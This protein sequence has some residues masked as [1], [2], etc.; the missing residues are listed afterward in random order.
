MWLA[1]VVSLSFLVTAPGASAQTT[2]TTTLPNLVLLHSDD[3]GWTYYGFMQRFVRENL[4]QRCR[5]NF[6]V[7]TTDADCGVPVVPNECVRAAGRCSDTAAVCT[8]NANCAVGARCIP[9]LIAGVG[10]SG[11]APEYDD[12]EIVFPDD[13]VG[14]S[15][16]AGGPQAGQYCQSNADCPSGTCTITVAGTPPVHTFITPAL[17]S[18][19]ES[20]SYFPY[21]RTSASICMP[22]MTSELTGL[23]I[24]DMVIPSGITN[25]TTSP[26]YSEWLPGY[27]QST[28]P[29]YLTMCAGK[30]SFGEPHLDHDPA[31]NYP[32]KRPWDRDMPTSDSSGDPSYRAMLEPYVPATDDAAKAAAGI[33]GLA[34]QRL[35][36]FIACARCST[37]NACTVPA[38]VSQETPSSRMQARTPPTGTCTSPQAFFL[39]LQPFIP[40]LQFRP[41]EYCPYFPRNAQQ[42]QTEPWHSHSVYCQPPWGTQYAY[43]DCA[44]VDE[45]LTTIKNNILVEGLTVSART[46]DA[47]WYSS[48]NVSYLR[49]VNVFDRAVDEVVTHLKATGLSG[50]T[51]VAY[52][53]DNGYGLSGSKGF[54]S[55]HGHRS[56]IIISSPFATGPQPSCGARVPGCRP[57]FAHSVDLLATFKDF[58]GTSAQ[59]CPPPN[60]VCGAGNACCKSV[61]GQSPPPNPAAP[62]QRY[63][64]RSLRNPALRTCEFPA[65]AS[66]ATRNV[67]AAAQ[68]R[69]RQCIVSRKQTSGQTITPGKGFYIL[70]EVEEESSGIVH[71]CKYYRQGSACNDANLF[72]LSFDP[73]E[74]VNLHNDVAECFGGADDGTKACTRNDQC[75]PSA[76]KGTGVC[77]FCALEELNLNKILRWNSMQNGWLQDDCNL[78]GQWPVP[79]G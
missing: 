68:S 67:P 30:C 5:R 70:A 41:D 72:D 44:K 24:S 25:K 8:T 23:H 79:E 9:S 18:L 49:F 33:A 35:K 42:C 26:V 16:C 22:A 60:V 17:D 63:E 47:N 7:C 50:S 37:T 36:D 74:N 77:K 43:P 54:F 6:N 4:D 34:M 76:A 51:V 38:G 31:N 3:Y 73:R 64:G 14:E 27:G 78:S 62:T 20:G 57:F 29:F 71:L 11:S 19:A 15:V 69:Y 66:P 40:H 61:A 12:Q 32:T 46:A 75:A 45:W 58:A 39:M 59:T 10:A 65:Y 1:A 56:P 28:L 55:E 13:N 52:V 21:A 48:A 2:T 53:T